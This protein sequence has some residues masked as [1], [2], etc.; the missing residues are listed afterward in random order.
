MNAYDNDLRQKVV[1]AYATGRFS[2][3]DLARNFGLSLS[4]VNDY[5]QLYRDTGS[6]DPK[7]HGGGNP[8]KFTLERE[9]WLIDYYQTHPD[10][11]QGQV[12]QAFEIKYG[13]RIS[14]QSIGK[15]LKILGWS[16]K[17]DV[18]CPG[19]HQ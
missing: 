9:E 15:R 6:V 3:R 8:G 5:C 16:K 7:P 12:A 4:C 18:L 10:H 19:N 14:A 1:D 17:K 2:Q 11:T 13:F